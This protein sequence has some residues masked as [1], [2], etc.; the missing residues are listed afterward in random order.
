[1]KTFKELATS[2]NESTKPKGKSVY[3]KI[4]NGIS[5]EVIQDGSKFIAYIDGDK[6]DTYSSQEQSVKMIVQFLK[7]FKG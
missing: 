5:T 3:S 2:L 1:M 4:V 7:Q 6:L